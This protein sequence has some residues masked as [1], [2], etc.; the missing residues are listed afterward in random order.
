MDALN[1]DDFAFYLGTHEVSWLPRRDIARAHARLFVAYPR[2][3]RRKSLPERPV[4]PFAIDS[5]AFSELS[6]HGQWTISP[7]EYVDYLLA[8]ADRHINP[9]WAASQDWPCE[10]P[11]LARTGKTIE[12][13]QH[14]S[15][16]N[17]CELWQLWPHHKHT[18]PFIPSLQGWEIDDY[19]RC[20]QLYADYGVR[21]SR[22]ALVGVGSICRRQSTSEA[23]DIIRELANGGL[24]LHGFGFKVEG[25]RRC[26]PYLAS[27]DSLAWSDG[28]RW[29]ARHGRTLPGC[30][31][32]TCSSC[33]RYA[34]AWH[35]RL[36]QA[37]GIDLP[38]RIERTDA[39]REA[40]ADR[41]WAQLMGA[42]DAFET[43]GCPSAVPALDEAFQG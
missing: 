35:R 31:H 32:A 1:D 12:E 27:A 28:A 30:T 25:L 2:L 36:R 43:K 23:H 40:A 37:L 19:L 39:E 34:L 15:V 9:D 3:R 5:G 4:M 20:R 29:D 38:D 16:Q 21:L 22:F 18:F 17:F 8:L 10:P 41:L 7:Q 6:L 11:M 26:A 14:L 24:R 33:W 13:H 42:L